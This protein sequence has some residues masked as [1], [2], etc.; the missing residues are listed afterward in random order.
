MNDSVKS[1]NK[2]TNRWGQISPLLLAEIGLNKEITMYM[3]F[4][5]KIFETII[6]PEIIKQRNLLFML[7]LNEVAKIFG[8][9]INR[10]WRTFIQILINATKASVRSLLVKDLKHILLVM[11]TFVR[12]NNYL[13]S[14]NLVSLYF[15]LLSLSVR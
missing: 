8:W 9:G 3:R 11:K 2:K 5:G 4:C 10:L 13:R 12:A 15:E 1:Y 6:Y 7:G 14:G